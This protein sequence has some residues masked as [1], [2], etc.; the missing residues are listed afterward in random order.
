MESLHQTL[1]NLGSLPLRAPPDPPDLR[2]YVEL[3][4][5]G[6]F[7]KEEEV[8]GMQR[9]GEGVSR[10]DFIPDV[11]W[12]NG[13]GSWM[14]PLNRAEEPERWQAAVDSDAP[15]IIQVDDG[16]DTYGVSRGI[17]PTSSSS[18]PGV[19]NRPPGTEQTDLG[20]PGQALSRLPGSHQVSVRLKPHY[21]VP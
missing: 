18:A 20:R 5:R 17:F 15:V 16:A 19:M 13:E 2:D 21:Q 9:H 7:P 4:L 10:A 12:V 3:A 6:G 8:F 1:R 11:I 14:V